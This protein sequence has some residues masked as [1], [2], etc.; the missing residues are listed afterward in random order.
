MIEHLFISKV[1]VK[2]LVL[3]FSDLSREIHIRGIVRK[4]DEEINSFITT[5]G[6][7]A[8]KIINEKREYI[9]KIVAELLEK[10]TIEREVFESI[11]GPKVA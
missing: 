1:R 2:L 8:V 10:E 6:Q 4:I 3:F 9:E 7:V 5:A 11:V